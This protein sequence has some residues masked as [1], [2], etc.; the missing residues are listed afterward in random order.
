MLLS[1][2][3]TFKNRLLS[4]V[5]QTTVLTGQLAVAIVRSAK[6]SLF[7]D[8]WPGLPPP[9]PNSE[10]QAAIRAA[11][12]RALA[13]R[14]PRSAAQL[15]FGP[16]PASSIDVALEPLDNQACNTHL[17]LLILDL[18]LIKL[19]PEMGVG[20]APAPPEGLYDG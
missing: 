12:V 2:M 9:E 10:E 20:G 7:P 4:H 14:L 11:L 13:E 8:G 1:N 5:L 19:F 16:D 17:V 15:L 3:L 18:V 6:H